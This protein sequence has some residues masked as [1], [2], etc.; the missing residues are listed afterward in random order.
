MGGR[1]DRVV[2]GMAGWESR[3][4]ENVGEYRGFEIFRYATGVCVKA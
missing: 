2:M 1:L 3:R 4:I